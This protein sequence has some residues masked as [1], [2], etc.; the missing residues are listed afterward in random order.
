MVTFITW[1]ALI[2][3]GLCALVFLAVVGV[4]VTGVI[5]AFKQSS[6]LPYPDTSAERIYDVQYF[7]RANG[8]TDK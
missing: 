6:V 5:N 8:R 4:G 7:Y 2:G 3:V 1:V